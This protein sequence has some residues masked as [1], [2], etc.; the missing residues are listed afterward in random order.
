MLT[1]SKCSPELQEKLSGVQC[2]LSSKSSASSFLP[3]N[4]VHSS[5]TS[6]STKNLSIQSG[7]S[8]NFV[9]FLTGD[10][11]ISKPNMTENTS[12]GKEEEEQTDF[13]DG[14]FDVNPFAPASDVPVAKVNNKVEE[15]GSIQ[16]YLRY[17]ESLSGN[18]KV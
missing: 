13:F 4:D 1:N 6:C 15:C 10:F 3:G 18:N 8:G 14:D 5:V 16:L 17:F 2:A 9:D 7:G 12:F 11:D